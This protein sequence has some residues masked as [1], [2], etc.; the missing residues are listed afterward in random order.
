[1]EAFLAPVLAMHPAFHARQQW[2]VAHNMCACE[3]CRK[4]GTLRVKFVAH[5]G[6]V[7]TS[8]G[9]DEDD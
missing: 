1:L 8:K 2:M 4:V 7:A 5:V 6:V 3:A 9:S